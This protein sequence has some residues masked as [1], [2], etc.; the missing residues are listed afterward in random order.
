[1]QKLVE[2]VENSELSF[3]DN[4]SKNYICYMT[5]TKTYFGFYFYYFFFGKKPGM[6]LLKSK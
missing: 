2:V 4:N 1:M 6:L 5:T 3:G